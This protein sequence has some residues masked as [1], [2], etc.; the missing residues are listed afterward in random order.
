MH[1]RQSRPGDQS[2][3][4]KS[5]YCSLSTGPGK[6][7]LFFSNDFAQTEGRPRGG[8]AGPRPWPVGESFG[9]GGVGGLG[10]QR[11][12]VGDTTLVQVVGGNG[13]R[14]HVAGQDADEV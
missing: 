1:K 12:A 13:D 6:D 9:G 10:P 5:L 11:A 7:R 14:D 3:Y 4:P 8:A 2:T